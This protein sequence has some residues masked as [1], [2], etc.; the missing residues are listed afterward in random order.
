M[1][2]ETIAAV[3]LVGLVAYK[4]GQQAATKTTHNEIN[5]QPDWWTYAGSWGN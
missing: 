2:I 1:T 5:S 4:A 3:L